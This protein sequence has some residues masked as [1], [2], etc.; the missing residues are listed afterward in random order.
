MSSGARGL[1]DVEIAQGHE[2]A[3]PTPLGEK[4]LQLAVSSNEKEM[5]VSMGRGSF[6]DSEGTAPTEEDLHTLVRVSGKLPWT[7]YTIAFVEMCERFSYYG[8][9]VLYTN[10][11]QQ[12]MP[13]GSRTGAGMDGQSGALGM[14]Q[15][16][17][18]GLV[19]FNTF[20]AY[21]SPLIGAY[22]ADQYLGRFK[23]IQWAICFSMVG[24]LFLIISAIPPVIVHSDASFGLF[25]IGLITVGCG[26]GGFKS[27]ISPLIA[28][29]VSDSKMK[30]TVDKKGQRVLMDP[31]VTVARVMM[32]FYMM[33]NVG[34]LIGQISMV[35][36]EKYVGFW[37][38][39]T[40]PTIL[41]CFC[42]IVLFACRSRYRLTPPAGSVTAKAAKLL[43]FAAK[44]RWSI[45][46]VKTVRNMRDMS[47]WENVK[48]S[49]LGDRK[50]TWMTFDDAWVDEVR[51]GIKACAVFLQ[52]PVFWLAYNQMTNNL[53]SQAAT[54]ELHGAPNDVINNMNPLS[55]VIFIPLFD[56]FV[57][58]ALRKAHINFTPLKRIGVGYI[59]ATCAMICATVMQHYIYKLGACGKHMNSCEDAD[60]NAIVSPIN[61][62]A[63]TLTYVLIGIA[64][65]FTMIT[66][67]EYAFT[68]APKNMRSVVTAIY[69][70]MNAISSAINQALL[71]LSEDPNLVWNYAVSGILCAIGGVVFWISFHRLDKD[72]DKL[73]MLPD[74]AFGGHDRR[75]SIVEDAQKNV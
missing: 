42:P 62:W 6:D 39:Y 64:E 17:S 37:L 46:P 40:L 28:E 66:S 54:M 3:A 58:P 51:R 48:P 5:G 24:H 36:A 52:L 4:E 15:Q 67:L 65:I 50:P 27:N 35:F 57:Y 41:F 38:A 44:G 7:T 32:Y 30:V 69:L 33:I 8:T 12:D 20:W 26:T 63:Q 43:F 68:K 60:G 56:N 75:H 16:A 45:N 73:N 14:G 18:T 11:I 21:T 23:T 10:Y 61:V 13:A 49:H 1:E 70:F 25:I 59:L 19:T 47:F 29:Q 2:P 53:T 74:S 31:A 72:E 34:S 22:I 55:L 9:S 71:P